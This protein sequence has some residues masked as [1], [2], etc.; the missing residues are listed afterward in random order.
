MYWHDIPEITDRVK[1]LA[2]DGYSTRVVARIVRHEFSEALGRAG[3]T[4][5]NNHIGGWANRQ[6]PKVVFAASRGGPR[7][8]RNV[9]ENSNK[10]RV[11]G[12]TRWPEKPEKRC[13]QFK[14]IGTTIRPKQ[15]EPVPAKEE[16][17]IVFDDG[18]FVTVLT[19]NDRMCR[20][21]IGNPSENEFRFCG[22]KPKSGSP[23]CEA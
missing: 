4:L 17:P 19:I 15:T 16:A 10:G 12:V 14:H 5:T 8:P 3:I 9:A 21:P 11:R 20:W 22:R 13:R 1:A 18:S 23:Y 2:K 6:Q 7:S